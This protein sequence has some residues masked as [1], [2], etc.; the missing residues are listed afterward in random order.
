MRKILYALAILVLLSSQSFTEA[1]EAKFTNNCINSENSSIILN[2]PKSIDNLIGNFDHEI[3]IIFS[4]IDGTIVPL[5]SANVQPKTPQSAI[6]TAKKLKK[7]HIPLILVTGRA[8]N[9]IQIIKKSMGNNTYFVLLQGGQIVNPKGK[10]IY[11]DYIKGDDIRKIVDDF[12]CFKKENNLNSHFYMVIDGKQYST[13]PF[14]LPYNGASVIV[15]KSLNDLRKGF[16]AA[17]FAVYEPDLQKCKLIQQHFKK[18]FPDYRVDIAGVGYV[19][20]SSP[21]ATKGN[22]IKR[23]ANILKV[24][25]KNAAA[26]G[27][28]ENDITMLK[29]VRNSGG[30]AIV[31]GN[32]MDTVKIN[33]N[34]VTLPVYDGGFAKAVDKI[35]ENNTL[36]K[37]KVK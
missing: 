8:P 3:K 16:C 27:D 25:L 20:I 7:A 18:N 22:A 2:S 11:E 1:Q 12:N 13:E 9:E 17:K 36:L 31:V 28:A 19:D 14:I 32:A 21:T 34:F 33:A 23:L 4:D 30:L 35:I 6:E 10:T 26:C 37:S 29:L 24:D 5:G 15:V